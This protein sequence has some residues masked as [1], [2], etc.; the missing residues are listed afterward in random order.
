MATA[1]NGTDSASPIAMLTAEMGLMKQRVTGLEFRL[2]AVERRL[3][4][5]ER[6]LDAVERRLGAVE[7]KL[8]EL[9]ERVARLETGVEYF[10]SELKN[11]S[12]RQITDFRLMFGSLITVAIGL[13]GM[14]AKGFGWL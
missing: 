13:A 6:R 10:Y 7:S 1:S 11:V 9:G 2:D 14:M 3:D 12:Q 8:A 4:A 5:V